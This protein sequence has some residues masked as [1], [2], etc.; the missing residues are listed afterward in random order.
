MTQNIGMNLYRTRDE[1]A[2]IVRL[3]RL[4]CL[5][6]HPWRCRPFGKDGRA[7]G[8][9]GPFA[10][11]ASIKDDMASRPLAPSGPRVPGVPHQLLKATSATWTSCFA[12]PRCRGR[13]SCSIW[14]FIRNSISTARAFLY[15]EDAPLDMR[16]DPG[17]N[18][19]NAAEVINTYNEHDLAPDSTRLRRRSSRRS[20]ANRAPPRARTDR[21]H[22][23]I[24]RDHQGG[25][26]R[27][28]LV[29]MART[30]QKSFGRTF[31]S[32]VNPELTCARAEL[33]AATG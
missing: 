19:L 14:A 13:Y 16:M 11:S 27:L 12:R 21:N 31:A 10:L 5:R 30:W 23:P 17:N 7:G 1:I 32:R 26:P 28:P 15:N 33:D 20:R 8:G 29:G 2:L 6:L 24:C 3:K 18:A 4:R 22:R 9:R 25:R